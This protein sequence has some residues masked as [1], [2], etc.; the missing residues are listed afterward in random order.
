[1][2]NTARKI[3]TEPTVDVV[4][5][6]PKTAKQWLKNNTRNRRLN[7]TTVERFA[8][9]MKAGAWRLNGETIKFDNFGA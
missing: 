4:M 6:T 8:N 7:I 2:N 5:V 1:M 3:Q 9:E